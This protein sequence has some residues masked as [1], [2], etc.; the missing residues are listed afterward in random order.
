MNQL[1]AGRVFAAVA[2]A[3][4][5]L[6]S[7]AAPSPGN[8]VRIAEDVARNAATRRVDPEYPPLARQLRIS[9]RVVVEVN[10]TA[11]GAVETVKSLS[12]NPMLTS[13]TVSAVKKW[14]F[15]PFKTGTKPV[16]AVTSLTFDFKL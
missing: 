10:I 4:A 8:L 13:A 9:G 16:R 2:V 12:G 11:A 5:C 6:C 7:D 3:L 15:N 14:K 1:W